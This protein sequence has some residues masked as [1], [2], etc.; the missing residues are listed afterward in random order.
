[1]ADVVVVD[2]ATGVRVERD[3]TPEEAAQ[4]ALDVA[5]AQEA[6]AV[7][8]TRSTN[9][10]TIEQQAALALQANRDFIASTPTNADAVAQVK[11]LSRQMNGV[12]RLLLNELDGDN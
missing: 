5:A 6:Q 3:F 4:R 10:L 7:E 11:A 12:I 9:R 8:A 1:M 2:A